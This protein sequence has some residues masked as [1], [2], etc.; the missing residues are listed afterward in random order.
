MP[1][2]DPTNLAARKRAPIGAPPGTLVVSHK[3]AQSQLGLICYGPGNEDRL[4]L[5]K[6]S[7]ADVRDARGR[8]PVM[9]LDVEGLADIALIQ[10]VADEFGLHLL[11]IEDVVNVHQ[12][13]KA[14]EFPDHVYVVLRLPPDRDSGSDEQISLFV[15]KDYVITFQEFEGDCFEPVRQRIGNGRRIVTSGPDYLAYALIDACV[16]AYFP[17]LEKLGEQVEDLEDRVI[18]DPEPGQASELHAMKRRLLQVRRAVWPMRELLN[19]LIR[20][21]NP[22]IAATTRVYLRDVYD[23]TIQLM[24]IIETY[25]EI[26]SGL[27]D[28]YLSSQS[29]KLN[30]VMK[31]L[32]IVATIFIPLSFLAGVWGMNFDRAA[33]PLNMPELS[34]YFGYPLALSSMAGMAVILLTYF[35]VKRW[36]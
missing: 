12:R 18:A 2:S 14:E 4:R 36:I 8:Y 28:V 24:D 13:P 29:A 22:N 25:R 20:D 32:T 11:S 23:H 16:D 19:N 30:E 35:K 21:E 6:C 33:S 31:F 34:W 15:G 10:E 1:A 3:A 26:A 9:W 27:L 7:M 17:V 5:E